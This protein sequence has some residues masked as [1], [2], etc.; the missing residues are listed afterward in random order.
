M[1]NIGPAELL[2]LGALLLPVL[3]GAVAL[4]VFAVRGRG[5]R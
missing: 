4:L 3:I 5:S 1:L 2:V